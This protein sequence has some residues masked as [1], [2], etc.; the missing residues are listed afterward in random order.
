MAFYKGLSMTPASPWSPW[1]SLNLRAAQVYQ[2]VQTN[3]SLDP[4][5]NV[6]VPIEQLVLALANKNDRLTYQILEPFNWHIEN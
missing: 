2:T 6:N 1:M 3:G 5:V 4:G